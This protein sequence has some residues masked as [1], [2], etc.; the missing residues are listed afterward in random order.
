TGPTSGPPPPPSDDAKAAL[1]GDAESDAKGLNAPGQDG[2]D[3]TGDKKV[4]S[5]KDLAKERAKADKA[6]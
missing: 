4:K 5:D 2:G 3:Q 1:L 6:A